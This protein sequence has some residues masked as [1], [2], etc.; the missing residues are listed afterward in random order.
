MPWRA[1]LAVWFYWERLNFGGPKCSS[2]D[3]V[4]DVSKGMV[5]PLTQTHHFVG[6][7]RSLFRESNCWTVSGVQRTAAGMRSLVSFMGTS[8]G[9]T[10]GHPE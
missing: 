8:R 1:K 2:L 9:R 4:P 3:S 10:V 5:K 7:N 6:R